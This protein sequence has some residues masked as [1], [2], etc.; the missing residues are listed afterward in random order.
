MDRRTFVKGGLAAAVA[1][2]V[3][4]RDDGV[5]LESIA[6]PTSNRLVTAADLSEE[7]L[8]MLLIQMKH[9]FP[10]EFPPS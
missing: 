5:T 10:H 6:H 4:W 3:P 1:V 9:E 2:A 7:S 8:E